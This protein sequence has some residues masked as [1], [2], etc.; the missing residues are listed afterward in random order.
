V[1]LLDAVIN[2]I[3]HHN[4]TNMSVNTEQLYKMQVICMKIWYSTQRDSI[5]YTTAQG[6][7]CTKERTG[8]TTNQW[9]QAGQVHQ[10]SAVCL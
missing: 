4:I 2:C 7:L 9:R 5:E 10:V 1:K 3:V 8:E 6:L